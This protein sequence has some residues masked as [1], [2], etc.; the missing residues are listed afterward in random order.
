MF[1]AENRYFATKSTAVLSQIVSH[2]LAE[3]C[4]F[5]DTPTS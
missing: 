4:R 2:C 5:L 1:E 3:R